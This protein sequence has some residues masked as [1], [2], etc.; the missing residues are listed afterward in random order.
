MEGRP[1]RRRPRR[2]GSRSCRTT[3]WR[4]PIAGRS[5]RKATTCSGSSR[6]T[7]PP[8]TLGW[9]SRKRGRRSA[10][11][12]PVD[13]RRDIRRMQASTTAHRRS[14]VGAAT[15]GARRRPSHPKENSE[16]HR[17]ERRLSEPSS[18]SSVSSPQTTPITA[19]DRCSPVRFA[20]NRRSVAGA[21]TDAVADEV[22]GRCGVRPLPDPVGPRFPCRRSGR[23][24]D[25]G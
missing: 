2:G 18:L 3:H 21:A 23:R 22:P 12:A 14:E 4:P 10:S 7:P 16:C 19:T 13:G 1:V 9:R 5:R 6:R 15:L 24:P 20:S 8:A 17:H 25:R 11:G